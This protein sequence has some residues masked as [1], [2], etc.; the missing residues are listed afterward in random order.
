MNKSLKVIL[1]IINLLMLILAILWYKEKAEYEPLIVILGQVMLLL[2]FAFERQASVIFTKDI[3]RS[4]IKIK[5]Q[6]GD[7]I[8]NENVNDS[9]INIS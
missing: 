1:V 3:N 4:Q 9:K 2:G 6:N 8:H 5:K 7:R